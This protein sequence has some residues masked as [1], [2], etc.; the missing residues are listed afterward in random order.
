M[1]AYAILGDTITL[2]ET[3]AAAREAVAAAVDV[4]PA[5]V[6]TSEAELDKSPLNM[7]Q[8]VGLWNNFAGVAPFD[9]LKPVKKFTDRK[10]AVARIWRAVQRL[11]PAPAAATVGEPGG[12][13][14]PSKT[15]STPEATARQGSKTAMVLEL[16][17]RPEGATLQDLMAATRWQAHS[18]RGFLSGSLHK[19]MGRKL[20]RIK[21]EDGAN[22]YLLE[23]GTVA[24]S[25]PPLSGA[26]IG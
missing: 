23:G 19:K 20:V 4:L 21:R 7:G 25:R 5:L 16:L 2:H 26:E 3:V 24:P 8:L 1:K 10:T 11:V 22:V 14:A 15:R 18:V 17:S 6:I 13:G 12:E 9:D